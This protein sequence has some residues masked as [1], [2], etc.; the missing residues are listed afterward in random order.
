MQLN[1]FIIFDEVTRGF[2]E[3]RAKESIDFNIR[4][5]LSLAQEKINAIVN[6]NQEF[7]TSDIPRNV[8]FNVKE[9]ISLGSIVIPRNSILT[10]ELLE[11]QTERRWHKSGFMVCK[12]L[13]YKYGKKGKNVDLSE[14]NIYLAVRKYEE[15]DGK[16]AAIIGTELV[17]AQAAGFFIP[18][19]DIAYYFT[20]GA[21]MREKYKN[22]FKSG[23][24]NAYDNSVFWFWLKGKPIDLEEDETV[25]LKSIDEKRAYKLKSQI[26]K[27]K[28]K[29]NKKSHSRLKSNDV[30]CSLEH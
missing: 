17:V 28:A 19:I 4:V 24:S 11:V 15:I 14:K 6:I 21:I 27:R 16:K 1:S 18:G 10:A 13:S 9:S 30:N 2:A 12:I 25:S 22:W 5:Q 26:E 8:E 23:V 7:S 29:K 20:K 3:H